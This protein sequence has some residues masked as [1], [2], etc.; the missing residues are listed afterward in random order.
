MWSIL[1]VLIEGLDLKIPDC[2]R[3]ICE[4]FLSSCAGLWCPSTDDDLMR[5]AAAAPTDWVLL[6]MLSVTWCPRSIRSDLEC[7]LAAGFWPELLSFPYRSTKYFKLI[8][9][10]H[11]SLAFDHVFH[12]IFSLV[13]QNT[14]TF[15]NLSTGHPRRGSS[16][17]GFLCCLCNRQIAKQLY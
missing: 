16:G 8:F 15:V 11:K 7:L 4:C 17:M 3:I 10:L 14:Q 6:G 1:G 5:D 13:T 9:M 2:L 12:E